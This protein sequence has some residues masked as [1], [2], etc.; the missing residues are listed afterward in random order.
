MTVASTSSP[1]ARSRAVPPRDRRHGK[2]HALLRLADPDFVVAQPGV[3][4][5]HFV[6]FDGR[7]DFFAHFADGAGS[8]PAPQS[9]MAVNKPAIARLQNHI[10]HFFSVMALPICTAW[11]NSSAWVSVSS[12]AGKCGAVN[13]IAAGA[14][15]HDDDGV[16]D[17]GLV[18]FV[19]RDQ[20][21]AAAEN[22]RIADVAI[23][24]ID[25]A[26][27]GGDAHAVAVIANAGD[28]LLQNALG[29]DDAFGQVARQSPVARPRSGKATQKTSV[30]A[31]GLA[32][33]PVPRIS[34]MTAAAPV[35]LPP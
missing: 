11:E 2:H 35:A 33:R 9:V 4:Q 15:A 30:L 17:G 28:D 27:D 26:V 8:P 5:R 34:R 7:A 16:A 22:Q 18:D 14:S 12:A 13:A 10:R 25:R 21:D 6:Q 23:V 1:A 20:P 24:E 19:A 3:F 31:I 32:A 29:M